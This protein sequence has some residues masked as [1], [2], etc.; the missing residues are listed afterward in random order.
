LIGKPA[1]P[2]ALELMAER[3]I[4]I[5]SHIAR[6]INRDMCSSADIILVMD[7]FQKRELEQRYP[8]A[9]GKVFRLVGDEENGVLD[10]YKLGRDAFEEALGTIER[11]THSWVSRI[12]KIMVKERQFI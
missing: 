10:P 3:N 9:R 2:I 7:S 1:D 8:Q 5:S 12:N 4:D 11:G 6:Q